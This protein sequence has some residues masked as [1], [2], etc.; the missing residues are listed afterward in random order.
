M[1]SSTGAAALLNRLVP[2]PT[3][4]QRA[5]SAAK[6]LCLFICSGPPSEAV[7]NS[8]GIL[9]SRESRFGLSIHSMFGR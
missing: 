8:A 4:T 5:G 2:I 9:G 6:L 3:E 7:R 1:V